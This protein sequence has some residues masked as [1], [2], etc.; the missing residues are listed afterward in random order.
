M[1]S[2]SRAGEKAMNQKQE[3]AIVSYYC[4]GEVGEHA[5]FD[6]RH[7]RVIGASPALCLQHAMGV[8]TAS[9]EI[10]MRGWRIIKADNERR[11]P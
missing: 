1:A 6:V 7:E 9:A 4:A 11:K 3:D 5:S 8:W 10:E 2:D